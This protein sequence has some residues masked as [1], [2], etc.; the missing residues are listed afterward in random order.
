MLMKNETDDTAYLRV[1]W[2]SLLPESDGQIYPDAFNFIVRKYSERH[3]RYHTLRHVKSSL[4]EFDRVRSRIENPAAV[5]YAIWFHD[6]V[7]NILSGRNEERSAETAERILSGLGADKEL[8][9]TVYR[10]ILATKHP[11][12]PQS[13]DERYI[14]DIDLS[15]LGA[16][17][18]DYMQ[19]EDEIRREYK[20]I[21]GF[22]YRRKR[23]AFLA[24]LSCR[25]RIFYTDEFFSAYEDKARGNIRLMMEKLSRR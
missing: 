22:I 14:A 8:I 11:A 2:L 24:A 17:S 3:R 1:R 12:A 16:E 15:I 4:A 18:A 19:Y 20:I 7:Y 25:E 13:G 6:I 9:T 21:P 5:E 23:A 10:L